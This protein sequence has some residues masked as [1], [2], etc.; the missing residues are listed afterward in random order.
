MQLQLVADV[1]S[2]VSGG[3]GTTWKPFRS[4]KLGGTNTFFILFHGSSF[5]QFPSTPFFR[6]TLQSQLVC[7]RQL[8]WALRAGRGSTLAW[9]ATFALGKW[10][11]AAHLLCVCPCALLTL[12]SS[13]TGW[14][15]I[16]RPAAQ[17]KRLLLCLP[18][19]WGCMLMHLLLLS[20]TTCPAAL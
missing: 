18:K 14:D 17:L 15:R 11:L 19:S 2:G 8:P 6:L 4:Q 10:P 7:L 9:H 3:T 13:T 5:A 20:C 16:P 12:V 1:P